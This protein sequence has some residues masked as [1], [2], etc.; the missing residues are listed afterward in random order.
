MTSLEQIARVW[1]IA[2]PLSML[3]ACSEFDAPGVVLVPPDAATDVDASTNGADAAPPMPEPMPL[4]TDQDSLRG[5]AFDGSHLYWSADGQ[6]LRID[7]T[8]GT[9]DVVVNVTGTASLQNIAVDETA[10]YWS[11]YTREE[12]LGA[13]KAGGNRTVLV[14]NL[15]VSPQEVAVDDTYVYWPTDD[16]TGYV[17]RV[18]KSLVGGKGKE[19]ILQAGRGPD[20][21]ALDGSYVYWVSGS[22]NGDGTINRIHTETG[23]DDV[24]TNPGHPFRDIAVDST[25]VYAASANEV[26]RVDKTGGDVEIL[27]SDQSNIGQLVVDTDAVYWTLYAT[28]GGVMRI[29]KDDDAAVAIANDQNRHT[30]LT[31][32]D[33]QLFWIV[34]STIM[35]METAGLE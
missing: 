24:L 6:I 21:I 34:E 29:S 35:T 9:I 26:M 27:A 25:H 7:L 33:G 28:D 13:P 4:V 18:E 12:V 1:F 2:A 20:D 22:S 5:L 10:V 31:I 3:L 11:D 14:D 16:A 30:A 15:D 32:G 17:M 23:A 8:S 19:T